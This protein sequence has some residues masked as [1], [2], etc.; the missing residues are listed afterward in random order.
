MLIEDRKKC[1]EQGGLIVNII[2]PDAELFPQEETFTKMKI[3]F[4]NVYLFGI[5]GVCWVLYL[6]MNLRV[7][8][9]M[10]VYRMYSLATNSLPNLPSS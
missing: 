2:H 10:E 6:A 5:Q 3:S 4:Y 9:G 7:H 1:F 8:I